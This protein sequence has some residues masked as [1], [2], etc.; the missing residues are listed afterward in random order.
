MASPYIIARF[1]MTS[2]S[3]NFSPVIIDNIRVA[4]PQPTAVT[5][6]ST[7][8]AQHPTAIYDL[9][10]RRLSSCQGKGIYIV[11]GRKVVKE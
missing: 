8:S 1:D 3:D 5:H 4:D 11:N 2:M 6:L 10:G 7:P 9:Q